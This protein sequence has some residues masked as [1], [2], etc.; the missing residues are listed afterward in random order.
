MGDNGPGNDMR[1]E[2]HGWFIFMSKPS[3]IVVLLVIIGDDVFIDT[4]K[5]Y[6]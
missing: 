4:F 1:Y 2:V 6:H 3:S 5:Y